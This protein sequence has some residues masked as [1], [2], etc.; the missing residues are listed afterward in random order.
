MITLAEINMKF[1]QLQDIAPLSKEEIKELKNK[2]E[3][4][5]HL[6]DIML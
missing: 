4:A 3:L 2:N 5:T 1:F 6:P